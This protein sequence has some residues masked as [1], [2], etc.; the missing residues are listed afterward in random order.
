MPL[1]GRW[2]RQRQRGALTFWECWQL[3]RAPN[4]EDISP[5]YPLHPPL[6]PRS[7]VKKE[8]VGCR[9]KLVSWG[10]PKSKIKGA[11]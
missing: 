8:V 1:K 5:P 2:Q 4:L 11:R 3:D 7:K 6:S 9:D 10:I